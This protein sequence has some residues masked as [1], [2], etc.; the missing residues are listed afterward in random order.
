M[1]L[2]NTQAMPAEDWMSV[3][4]L[5]RPRGLLT[6]LEAEAP[7]ELGSFMQPRSAFA[8]RPLVVVHGGM[9]FTIGELTSS[10]EAMGQGVTFNEWSLFNADARLVSGTTAGDDSINRQHSGPPIPFL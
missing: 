5:H 6:P 8:R 3:S 10:L 4:T 1:A 7:A 2:D 9:L